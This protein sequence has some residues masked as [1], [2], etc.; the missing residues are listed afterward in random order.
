MPDLPLVLVGVP[1]YNRLEKLKKTITYLLNQSYQNIEVIVSDNHS[2]DSAVALFLDQISKNDS[3]IQF[4]L[5]NENIEIEPNFNFVYQQAKGEY[6]MW[7][8]DDDALDSD[9]IEKCVTFLEN[10]KDYV[11]CSGISKYYDGNG[12]FLFQEKK[13]IL[14]NNSP[15]ERMFKYFLQVNK[16]G[17]FYGVYRNNLNF[18]NPVQKHPGGDWNHVARTTLLGKVNVLE[19]V[20]ISRSDDGSSA[21]RQRITSRWNA[22]G[23]KKIFFETYVAFQVS[24]FLFNERVLK[25][26]YSTLTRIIIQ[27]ILFSLLNCKFLFHFFRIRLN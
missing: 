9:Y 18:E 24:Y 16:N 13:I 21:S 25:S 3:R 2:D 5:Q 1:T 7:V 22:K 11:L 8:S 10:N 20:F 15:L 12:H 23:I 17:V 19:N 27:V 14:N 26:R 4:F 6:F